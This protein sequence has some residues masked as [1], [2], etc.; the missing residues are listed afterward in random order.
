MWRQPP[1]AVDPSARSSAVWV[2]AARARRVLL[3]R[4]AEGGCPHMV[5][6]EILFQIVTEDAAD[7]IAPRRT[8]AI[9]QAEPAMP[10][11]RSTQLIVRSRSPVA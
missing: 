8:T 4:T 7:M 10:G 11:P 6:G 2:A 1:S 3:D 5:R 9:P